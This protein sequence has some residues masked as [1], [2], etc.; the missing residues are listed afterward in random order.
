MFVQ[1]SSGQVTDVTTISLAKQ[2]VEKGTHYSTVFDSGNNNPKYCRILSAKASHDTSAVASSNQ[3]TIL[4]SND[5]ISWDDIQSVQFT[6]AR[7]GSGQ[8]GMQNFLR[9]TYRYVKLS[10]KSNDYEKVKSCSMQLV[11]LN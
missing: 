9:T 11:L 6:R 1:V 2:N 7:R 5:N 3:I 8:I 4:G 10:H